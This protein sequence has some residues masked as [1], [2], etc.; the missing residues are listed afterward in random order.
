MNYVFQGEEVMLTGRT[1]ERPKVSRRGPDTVEK[2]VEITP[3]STTGLG[4]SWK[5]WVNVAELY[6][7]KEN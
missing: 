1:A 2:L 4:T 6:E 5:K 3:A 7:I